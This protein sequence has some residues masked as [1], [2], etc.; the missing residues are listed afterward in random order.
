MAGGNGARSLQ[1]VIDS[2]PNIIDYLFHNQKSAL[3]PYITLL[4]PS[5]QVL[6]EFTNWRDEQRSWWESVGL[7]D[8]TFHLI[9]LYLRGRDVIRLLERLGVNS[10]KNFVPGRA[11]EFVACAPSG[12]IIGDAIL[13]YLEPNVLLLVGADMTINWIHYYAES[14]EYDVQVEVD[15]LFFMNPAGRRTVYR[16]E[17]E[18]PRAT[19]LLEK[20]GR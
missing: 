11:K 16:F 8:Q 10:F 7:S 17:I 15:P 19:S 20:F 6:P 4:Q 3:T 9:N 13:Y 5:P 18:G 14:G 12:H 1:D 2:V